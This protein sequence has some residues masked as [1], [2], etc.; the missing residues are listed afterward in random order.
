M[1]KP[2]HP[3]SDHAV[4]RYLEQVEGVDIEGLRRDIGRRVDEVT[5]GHEGMSSVLIDGFRYRIDEDER[6][7]TISRQCGP[8]RGQNHTRSPRSET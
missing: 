2:R 1:K 8:K 4:L 3:V 6:I 7:T 5:E